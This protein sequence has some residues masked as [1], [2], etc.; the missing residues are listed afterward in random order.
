M[1]TDDVRF[2][3]QIHTEMPAVD[4]YLPYSAGADLGGCRGCGGGGGVAGGGPPPP[5]PRDDLR[6]SNTA[7]TLQKKNLKKA[8]VHWC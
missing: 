4:I 1:D 7:G 5:P 8:M 3:G 2:S 6:F